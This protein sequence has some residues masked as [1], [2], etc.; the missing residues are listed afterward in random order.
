VNRTHAIEAIAGLEDPAGMASR[1]PKGALADSLRAYAGWRAVAVREE[2]LLAGALGGIGTASV[3][4]VP[5]LAEDV[6]DIRSLREVGT[7]LAL[8]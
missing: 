1:L 6:V 3:W 2:N 5:D 7:L 4:R 8:A